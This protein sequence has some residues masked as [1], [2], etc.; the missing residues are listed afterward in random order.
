MTK[1]TSSSQSVPKLSVAAATVAAL[2]LS[3]CGGGGGDSG[4]KGASQ[5]RLDTTSCAYRFDASI[6]AGRDVTCGVLVAP[7]DRR[8][9]AGPQ[10]RIPYAVFKA[11]GA[12][13]QSPIVYLTGGPGET[14]AETVSATKTGQ[15]PG[16][17]GGSKLQRD[18][19]VI[20]Q[21]GSS[22]TEPSLSCEVPTWYPE[23]YVDW[24]KAQSAALVNVAACA[25]TTTKAPRSVKTAGFNTNELAADVA[26]LSRLLGYNKVVLNG[27][28]YGTMWASAVIRDYPSLVESAV[29]DSVVQQSQPPLLRLAE[30]FEPALQAVSQ[31]CA[32]Y[33]ECAAGGADLVARADAVVRQ[34][35]AQPLGWRLG[36]DGRFTSGVFLT[37]L[38]PL[39]ASSPSS[40]PDFIGLIESLIASETGVDALTAEEQSQLL[41]LGSQQGPQTSYQGQFLSIA[42][43][44]NA[45]LSLTQVQGQTA[46]I[47]PAFRT[48]VSAVTESFYQA[49][50]LWPARRDLPAS[51]RE[52]V[53]SNIP[54]LIL[55]GATDPL[56]PRAWALE[57]AATLPSATLVRFPLR[58]HSLQSGACVSSIVNTFLSK[59]SPNTACAAN[60]GGN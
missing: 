20:E 4:D 30:G 33:P 40:V 10:V 49:C 27:V 56:T 34:L 35:D 31:A 36:P 58:G 8:D 53:R 25:V 21:R 54:V 22:A 60:D 11:P 15:S 2:L 42:C 46:S 41:G 12:S 26:D 19:V 55:S 51:S 45:S 44:D 50:Q 14:W 47:R 5:S 16:F 18:E 43:A 17:V 39:M 9:P 29:L 59:G 3:A 13:T 38:T 28:S 48:Y 32:T 52:P 24:R 23:A 6:V 37:V 7:Q 1:F 57:A